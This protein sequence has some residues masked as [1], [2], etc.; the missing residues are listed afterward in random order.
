MMSFYWNSATIPFMEDLID[1]RDEEIKDSLIHFYNVFVMAGGTRP[2]A[3]SILDL[4]F[5][6]T[7]KVVS[8]S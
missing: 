7:V 4:A 1:H 8:L 2:E 6:L 3:V 5:D